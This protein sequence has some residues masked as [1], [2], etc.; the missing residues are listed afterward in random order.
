MEKIRY[1][2]L[3]NNYWLINT[4]NYSWNA[5]FLYVTQ[6][7]FCITS[8][9]AKQQN[10][11]KTALCNRKFNGICTYG[12]D[13]RGMFSTYKYFAYKYERQMPLQK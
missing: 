6:F 13:D 5:V 3:I 7:W 9:A 8:Y 2:P 4:G 12:K 10:V 11:I 1:T